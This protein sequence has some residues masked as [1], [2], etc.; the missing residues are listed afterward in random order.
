MCLD[1]LTI[2]NDHSQRLACS[3]T[4]QKSFLYYAFGF[5]YQLTVYKHLKNRSILLLMLTISYQIF[6]LSVLYLKM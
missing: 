4:A 6:T 3:Q 2:R 1:T 5:C